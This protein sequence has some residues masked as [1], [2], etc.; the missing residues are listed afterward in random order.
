MKQTRGKK[1]NKEKLDIPSCLVLVSDVPPRE[2]ARGK[3]KK[4]EGDVLDTNNTCLVVVDLKSCS[5]VFLFYFIFL[6]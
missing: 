4:E 3:R 5:L 6:F 1:I 2:V